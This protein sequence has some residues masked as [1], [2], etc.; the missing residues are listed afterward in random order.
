MQKCNCCR[1]QHDEE[2]NPCQGRKIFGKGIL[3]MGYGSK[4]DFNIYQFTLVEGWYCYDCLDKE[5]AQGLCQPIYEWKGKNITPWEL[6]M[7]KSK[8]GWIDKEQ[9][10]KNWD[11]FLKFLGLTDEDF[12]QT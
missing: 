7:P 3:M 1:K 9:A 6:F 12:K 2:E 11:K 8:D 10:E 5:V 4:Y